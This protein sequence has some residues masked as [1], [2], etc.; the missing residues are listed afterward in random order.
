MIINIRSDQIKTAASERHNQIRN[1][2]LKRRAETQNERA[3]LQ[4]SQ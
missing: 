4:G 3:H 1:S 2:I